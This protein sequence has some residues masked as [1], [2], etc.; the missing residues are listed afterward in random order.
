MTGFNIVVRFIIA[1]STPAKCLQQL[2]RVWSVVANSNDGGKMFIVAPITRPT[3]QRAMREIPECFRSRASEM[4]KKNR[5][6]DYGVQLFLHDNIHL[7]ILDGSNSPGSQD[8]L[9]PGLLQVDDV[10]AV[11]LLLEDVLLHRGLAV[12]RADV[13]GGS[14]HLGDVI[15]LQGGVGAYR[16]NIAKVF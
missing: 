12:I 14:Q 6:I 5:S 7:G 8:Q 4:Q 1:L 10:D 2:P 11:S 13:R 15:L 16:R 3:W 9:L